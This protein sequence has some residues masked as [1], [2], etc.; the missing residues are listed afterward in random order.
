MQNKIARGDCWRVLLSH[1][2][3]FSGPASHSLYGDQFIIHILYILF[4]YELATFRIPLFFYGP[5][6]ASP[7]TI[8]EIHALF[9]FSH[10]A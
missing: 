2:W 8:F 4:E 10:M 5:P 7:I 3:G 6:I 9:T 1:N